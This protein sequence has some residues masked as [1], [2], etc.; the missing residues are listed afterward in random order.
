MGWFREHQES[1]S[2]LP[3]PDIGFRQEKSWRVIL[4]DRGKE[5]IGHKGSLEL[6]ELNQIQLKD[7][8]QFFFG[9]YQFKVV[10]LVDL[11]VEAIAVTP[12]IQFNEANVPADLRNL[13]KKQRERVKYRKMLLHQVNYDFHY[14]LIISMELLTFFASCSWAEN[15]NALR[16]KPKSNYLVSNCWRE[17]VNYSSTTLLWHFRFFPVMWT[18]INCKYL[19]NVPY[20]HPSWRF[21][22][23]VA[24]HHVWLVQFEFSTCQEAGYYYWGVGEPHKAAKH[25]RVQRE[26]SQVLTLFRNTPIHLEMMNPDSFT[27]M[28]SGECS[29]NLDTSKKLLNYF[30]KWSISLDQQW[31]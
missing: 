24:F 23:G 31:L 8:E 22:I 25:L 7:L 15:F 27:W 20:W 19:V 4:N 6:N 14:Q 16:K 28:K 17:P 21:G 11:C 26:Y 3:I 30:K 13:L 5:N 2:K 10:S 12:E 18:S 9:K 1:F 29:D